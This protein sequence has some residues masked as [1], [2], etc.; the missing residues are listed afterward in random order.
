V[1][2]SAIICDD[3]LATGGTAKATV[4]LIGGI[5]GKDVVRIVVLVEL[6]GLSG[7]KALKSNKSFD[8]CKGALRRRRF[9]A[10]NRRVIFS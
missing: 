10:C 2:K 9:R 4:A 5:G 1:G 3:L 6:L 7:A 8:I